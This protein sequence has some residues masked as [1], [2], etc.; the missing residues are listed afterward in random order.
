MRRTPMNRPRRRA[1]AS[2]ELVLVFP[3]LLTI[4]SALFLIGKADLMKVQAVIDARRQTWRNRPNAPSGQ[5]LRPWHNPQDSEISSL[6]QRAVTGGPPF[7]GQT[8]QAQSGN[9]LIANPWAS[10]AIPFPSLDQN[11]K[12]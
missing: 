12:P 4:V 1:I 3:F 9:A 5:L 11:L 8:F 2:L 7:S 10:Q 6:P